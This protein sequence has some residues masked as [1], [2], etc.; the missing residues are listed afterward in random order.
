MAR[1]K[2]GEKIV[3]N[4]DGYVSAKMGS[5]GI[6]QDEDIIPEVLFEN[7]AM[8]CVDELDLEPYTDPASEIAQIVE[9]S[10]N[11]TE[12]IPIDRFEFRYADEYG[13]EL[14]HKFQQSEMDYG[15]EDVVAEFAHYLM[16]IGWDRE[17]VYK[18][19]REDRL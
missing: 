14:S 6:V 11:S 18:Y 19:I 17:D 1:F 4:D 5:V 2:V 8:I 12:P 9:N 3:L 7:G 16:G 10:I 13:R 15:L